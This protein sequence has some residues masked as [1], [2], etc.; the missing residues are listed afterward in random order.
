MTRSRWARLAGFMFLFYI[1]T[2]MPASILYD[3]A[4]AG[5]DIAAKLANIAAHAAQMRLAI[6][7]KLITILDALILG[8]ALYAITRDEDRD[9][10]V[11][12][13]VC[14]VAEGVISAITTIAALAVLFVATN[15]AGAPSADAAAADALGAVLI[16]IDGWSTIVGATVF[17]AGSALFSLLFLRARSIPT[18][19]AWLGLLASLLVFV[20]LPCG[21]VGVTRSGMA[22]WMWLPMLAFE[23]TLGFWLLIKGMPKEN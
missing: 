10:A 20:A 14:R 12:A 17:A 15:A 5:H 6:L 16:K 22:W 23:V 11:L 3:Q 8:V 21:L 4:V 9:L 2:A 13:L 18:P 19:L 1:A 7:F